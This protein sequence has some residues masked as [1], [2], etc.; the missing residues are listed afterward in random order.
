MQINWGAQKGKA[1]DKLPKKTL[2]IFEE[3]MYLVSKKYDG[4]QIFISKTGDK[5]RWFTSD[6]KEFNL[7]KIGDSLHMIEGDF[8]IVCEMNYKSL[9]KLGDRTE[10]QGKITTE[11]IRFKKGLACQL[12]EELVY[13]RAFDYITFDGRGVAN[14]KSF[15]KRLVDLRLL[16]VRLP[17]NIEVVQNILM[18]GKDAIGF[19]DYMT[20][21]GWEGCMLMEPS[22]Y[23]YFNKRVNH[24]I[25][26]KHRYTADLE[27]IDTELG[28]GK[29]A[30]CIGSL[31]L[32]DKEG[33][34]VKVGSGLSD[35]DRHYHEDY[36]VGK[37]IEIGYEQLMDTYIQPTFIR[38]RTDKVKGE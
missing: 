6:W 36:Y 37:V 25:K 8:T 29:Y 19:T 4:N 12:C 7:P 18:K 2:A 16:E 17:E 32:K 23:Y 1:F 28:E 20:Q 27:C 30:D 31:V 38:V 33:R 5:V 26:L 15:E 3:Q 24:S 35:A 13:L 10:V 11:R 14:N 9:G 34:Q 22:Q 21:L